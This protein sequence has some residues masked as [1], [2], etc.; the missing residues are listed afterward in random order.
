MVGI[1]QTDIE[2]SALVLDSLRLISTAILERDYER[3][4]KY[5]QQPLDPDRTV[6]MEE[7]INDYPA[8][9]RPYSKE[10]DAHTH[11][12]ELSKHVYQIEAPLVEGHEA[13][14]TASELIIILE[15]DD[16]NKSFDFLRVQPL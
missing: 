1:E 8:K 6:V 2:N 4:K 13:F 3:L 10:I 7:W 9:L 14:P 16:K 5:S 15:Y 12:L 11:Y